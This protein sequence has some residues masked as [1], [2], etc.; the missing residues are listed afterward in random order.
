MSLCR[1][2]KG[3]QPIIGLIQSAMNTHMQAQ[4]EHTDTSEQQGPPRN[5]LSV[6]W[7]CQP[8]H[9]CVG[10]RSGSRE[11]PLSK[12]LSLIYHGGKVTNQDNSR[13]NRLYSIQK[14]RFPQKSLCWKTLLMSNLTINCRNFCR[15]ITGVS[16]LSKASGLFFI[17]P[18][19]PAL[20]IVYSSF[21]FYLPPNVTF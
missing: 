1:P 9:R 3:H 11:T 20:S 6:G 16:S 5:L 4:E 15:E 14:I 8:P 10:L 12:I 18:N 13:E 7:H 2:R 17:F 21:H 19:S